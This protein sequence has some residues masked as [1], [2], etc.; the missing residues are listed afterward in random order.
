[1]LGTALLFAFTWINAESAASAAEAAPGSGATTWGTEDTERSARAAMDHFAKCCHDSNSISYIC[2]MPTWELFWNDDA[3]GGT[4]GF[5]NYDEADASYAWNVISE[6][7]LCPTAKDTAV[8]MYDRCLALEKSGTPDSEAISEWA[9]RA[10]S[11]E[12]EDFLITERTAA[13]LAQGWATFFPGEEEASKGSRRGR[14]MATATLLTAGSGKGAADMAKAVFAVAERREEPCVLSA[15]TL[16]TLRHVISSGWDKEDFVNAAGDYTELT[17]ADKAEGS[18]FANVAEQGRALAVAHVLA[19]RKVVKEQKRMLYVKLVSSRSPFTFAFAHSLAFARAQKS[20]PHTRVLACCCLRRR[21][22]ASKWRVIR[23]PT[24]H[25]CR[26]LRTRGFELVPERDIVH[27]R[28]HGTTQPQKTQQRQAQHFRNRQHCKRDTD[29]RNANYRWYY[30][31]P[32]DGRARFSR[33]R[34]GRCSAEWGYCAPRGRL[35]VCAM[36]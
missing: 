4:T 24:A 25:P 20:D 12:P 15:E 6:R 16:Q 35:Q 2:K 18:L 21:H 34:R 19:S 5:E 9:L 13:A 17:D 23:P 11:G 33:R 10:R 28:F 31:S 29:E 36:G 8:R 30:R 14:S 22:G 3:A 1:M 32:T 27:R 7:L 26:R